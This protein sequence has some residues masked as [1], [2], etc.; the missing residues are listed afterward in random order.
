MSENE[1]LNYALMHGQTFSF[2]WILI[3]SELES[4]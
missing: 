1:L 3:Y 4:I 2:G